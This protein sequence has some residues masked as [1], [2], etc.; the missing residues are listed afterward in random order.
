MLSPDANNEQ[1]FTNCKVCFKLFDLDESRPLF[2]Q[3]KHTFC[4][5]CLKVSNSFLS[6]YL[7]ILVCLTLEFL[8]YFQKLQKENSVKCPL[9]QALTV[10]E[11][12]SD[13]PRNKYTE[14]IVFMHHHRGIEKDLG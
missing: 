13:L 1:D 6:L 9:C 8:I 2:L 14:H 3:C 10:I 4:L 12:I 7:K 11:D 5:K